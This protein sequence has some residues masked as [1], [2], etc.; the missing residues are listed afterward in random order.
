MQALWR[1]TLLIKPQYRSTNTSRRKGQ[2]YDSPSV[3]FW[4]QKHSLAVN[5]L[6]G[7]TTWQGPLFQD[8]YQG[9][10]FS[11]WE[12]SRLTLSQACCGE[13]AALHLFGNQTRHLYSSYEHPPNGGRVPTLFKVARESTKGGVRDGRF[14]AWTSVPAQPFPYSKTRSPL[15][16]SRWSLSYLS[17]LTFSDRLIILVTALQYEEPQWPPPQLLKTSLP[18]AF[19]VLVS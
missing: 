3:D 7:H 13:T 6:R 18:L 1:V 5:L 9:S 12:E 8:K 19:I 14:G 4:F 11:M 16:L 2:C 15:S 17:V 10:L